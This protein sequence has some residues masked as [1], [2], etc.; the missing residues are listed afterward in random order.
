MVAGLVRWDAEADVLAAGWVDGAIGRALHQARIERE[1]DRSYV[2]GR[3]GGREW[4]RTEVP[5]SLWLEDEPTGLRITD[6]DEWWR[7]LDLHERVPANTTADARRRHEAAAAAAIWTAKPRES[8]VGD[9]LA[10]DFTLERR[11]PDTIISFVD[12]WAG[13]R[14][15]VEFPIWLE[16]HGGVDT[17]ALGN[18]WLG[19]AEGMVRGEPL[20]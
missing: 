9:R 13:R 2:R 3:W 6:P 18:F 11:G 16:Q 12:E 5:S 10:A 7:Q 4:A 15:L 20:P 8:L 17:D 1:G 14:E 19:L